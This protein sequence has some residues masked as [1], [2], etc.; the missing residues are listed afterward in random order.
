MNLN[1]RLNRCKC[2]SVGIFFVF[3][4]YNEHLMNKEII[5]S[6]VRF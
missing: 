6:F 4:E 2:K 5:K 3:C 1:I